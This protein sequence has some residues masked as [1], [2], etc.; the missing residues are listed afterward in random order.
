M[1]QVVAVR[2]GKDGHHLVHLQDE[3]AAAW[4]LARR[5]PQRRHPGATR[6]TKTKTAELR[7]FDRVLANPPFSQNYAKTKSKDDGSGAKKKEPIA[8]PGRFHVWMPEKGKR[9]T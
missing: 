1:R 7:R 6:S 3:H 5:H 4:H 2:P 8:H 9:P